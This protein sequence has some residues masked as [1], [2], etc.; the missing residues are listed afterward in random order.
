MVITIQVL[1]VSIRILV[2]G[3]GDSMRISLRSQYCA[4]AFA[5]VCSFALPSRSDAQRLRRADLRAIVSEVLDSLVQPASSVEPGQKWRRR[6][7]L[8]NAAIF[9]SFRGRL[10]FEPVPRE[11]LVVRADVGDADKTILDDCRPVGAST[12]ARLEDRIYAALALESYA[13]D[14]L[15]VQVTTVDAGMGTHYQSAGNAPVPVRR[16]LGQTYRVLLLRDAPKRR[17]V[18]KRVISAIVG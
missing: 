5:W 13:G 3:R 7:W 14:S 17:W 9:A 15:I 10:D 6:V 12:C 18:F 1:P 8:N 11:P 2:A 16:S 4:I